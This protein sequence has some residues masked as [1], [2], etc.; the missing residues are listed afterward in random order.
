MLSPNLGCTKGHHIVCPQQRV[1]N[2]E[3]GPGE[4]RAQYRQAAVHSSQI[5]SWPLCC[6][7][8]SHGSTTPIITAS[9]GGGRGTAPLLGGVGEPCC[10]G[11]LPPGSGT[12][13]GQGGGRGGE[14]GGATPDLAW[15]QGRLP[16][17]HINLHCILATLVKGSTVTLVTSSTLMP[18]VKGFHSCIGQ[19]LALV[20]L[21]WR[22]LWLLL[23]VTSKVVAAGHPAMHGSV[24]PGPVF[25]LQHVNT[26]S[27]RSDSLGTQYALLCQC[28]IMML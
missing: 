11:V 27:R 6:A 10:N 4:Q 15:T 12:M 5:C 8:L 7:V 13:A 19:P 14:E 20:F 16:L 21:V 9:Q 25:L 3:V 22:L 26:S 28:S 2:M 17:G 24:S 18:L 23:L 1:L